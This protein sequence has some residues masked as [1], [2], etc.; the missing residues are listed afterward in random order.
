[1]HRARLVS[2]SKADEIPE[3]LRGFVNF[4]ANLEG[5][6][7]SEKERVAMLV[8]DGTSCYVP[9]FL[10]RLKKIEELE[11]RLAEQQA[12]MPEDTRSL[13]EKSIS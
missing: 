8:I 5:H 1:M 3:H 4:Q 12:E 6:D 9:V 10:D 2:I 7:V 11:K 13:L